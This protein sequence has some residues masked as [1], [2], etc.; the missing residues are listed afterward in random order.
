GIDRASL[1]AQAAI[2]AFDHVDIVAGGAPRTVIPT[3]A[4]FNG[5]RLRRADR[6]AQLAGNAALLAIGVAAQRMF[7]AETWRDRALLE[8]VIER[9]LGLEEI[10]H[11][12][13]ERRGE[14]LEEHRA[15]HLVELHAGLL[16][17]PQ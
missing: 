15:G 6:L 8:R 5:D 14:F 16:P 7:A 17:A 13:H 10:A 3:R 12:E 4:G 2:D 9:R 1:L 11:G